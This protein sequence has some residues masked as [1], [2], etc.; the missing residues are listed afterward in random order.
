MIKV[1]GDHKEEFFIYLQDSSRG[2][3]ETFYQV[4]AQLSPG[5]YGLTLQVYHSGAF[6]KPRCVDGEP[7]TARR[8]CSPVI[9]GLSKAS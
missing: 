9:V 5:L 1:F 3:L 7:Y 2:F 4:R 6:C 8:V